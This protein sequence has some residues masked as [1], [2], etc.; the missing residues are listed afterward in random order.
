MLSN[1][2]C[3]GR[4]DKVLSTRELATVK[5]HLF[6]C[7]GKTCRKH[8]ADAVVEGLKQQVKSEKL[9]S[10][11]IITCMECVNRC[12]KGP[13]VILYPKGIWYEQIKK[14]DCKRIIKKIMKGKK[15][16]SKL[17]YVFRKDSSI[18]EK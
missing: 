6:V 12:S 14:K 9:S 2:E 13:I 8:G 4:R 10:E 17:H 7:V 11:L 5:N 16:K 1:R 3:S 18:K 15:Y